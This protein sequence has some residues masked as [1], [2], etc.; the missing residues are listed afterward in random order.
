MRLRVW[1]HPK[2]VALRNR[3]NAVM[4]NAVGLT[5]VDSA[6]QP[7]ARFQATR[8]AFIKGKRVH[9]RR[10]ATWVINM[11][12][13]FS[14]LKLLQESVL[15]EELQALA[16]AYATHLRVAAARCVGTL[17]RKSEMFLIAA[18]HAVHE[19][20]IGPVDILQSPCVACKRNSILLKYHFDVTSQ[21]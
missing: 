16:D 15:G 20:C 12:S 10:G 14:D 13:M 17:E 5:R 8:H 11:D 7:F 6:V 4:A 2:V 9:A 21:P 19:V 3:L 18:M 1:K